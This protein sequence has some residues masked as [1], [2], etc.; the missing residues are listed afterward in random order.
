M[1]MV[2]PLIALPWTALVVGSAGLLWYGSVAKKKK[3]DHSPVAKLRESV[4][5]IALPLHREVEALRNRV[6]QLEMQFSDVE[7]IVTATAHA[8]E[9]LSTHFVQE[10]EGR[11]KQPRAVEAEE[12]RE[13]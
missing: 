10:I 12:E 6:E 5:R 7:Q 13:T 3:E 11:R 9:T 1:M 2:N 4:P 8:Q